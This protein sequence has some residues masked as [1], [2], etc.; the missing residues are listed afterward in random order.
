MLS[1][2]ALWTTPISGDTEKR[3][4]T[5]R[6]HAESIARPIGSP[7]NNGHETPRPESKTHDPD[8]V[9]NENT[10][11]VYLYPYPYLRAPNTRLS[12]SGGDIGKRRGGVQEVDQSL[13]GFVHVG[14]RFC[15]RQQTRPSSTGRDRKESRGAST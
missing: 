8:H 10:R 5:K 14:R 4:A 1:C 6:Q 7:D 2:I 3:N 11:A 13:D 12:I 9:R 15:S